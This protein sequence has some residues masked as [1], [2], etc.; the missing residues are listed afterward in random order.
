MKAPFIVNDPPHGP[1]RI[2]NT[3]RLAHALTNRYRSNDRGSPASIH[4]STSRAWSSRKPKDDT[5][6]ISP[7]IRR[8]LTQ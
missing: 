7:L 3:L 2:Y 8:L 4:S 6:R 1:E 5:P